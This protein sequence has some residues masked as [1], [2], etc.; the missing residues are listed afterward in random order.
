MILLDTHVV[1]W[2]YTG[3]RARIPAAVQR[4]ID[5]EQVALSPFALLEL[6]YLQEIGRIT[7]SATTIAAEMRFRLGVD[8]TDVPAAAVC[9]TALALTWT[10]DPFDRLLAAHA[11]VNAL[12]LVTK[13]ETIRAHL[14]LA[15]WAD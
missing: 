5:E 6:G 2:L 8:V 1:L 11:T 14:P 15:W 7:D 10:T 12:P 9:A 13:D 3:E 4:R